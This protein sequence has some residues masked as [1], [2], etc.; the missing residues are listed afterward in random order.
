[1]AAVTLLL[2]AGAPEALAQTSEPT[3]FKNVK[4]WVNPEYDDPLSLNV[5][6]L[7]IMIEGEIVGPP[8][9]VTI[10]FL[11]PTTASMYSAGSKNSFGEYKG[12]P[13]NRK[14]STVPGYDE[15]SYQ[16]TENTFRVE[17]YNPI[18][19]LGVVQR[20]FSYD[21][22]RFYTVQDLTVSVQQP[23][24]SD[25]FSASSSDGQT[26]SSAVDSQGF[27]IQTYKYTNLDASTPIGFS[28]SYNRSVWE[29]SLATSPTTSPASS[30]SSSS[31]GLIVAIVAIAVVL[32]AGGVYLIN[33][34]SQKSRPVSRAERRRRGTATGSKA[35]ASQDTP[36]FCSQCGRKLDRPSRFCPDCGAEI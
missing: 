19:E 13:P 18:A 26:G 30:K 25:N 2:I 5:P 24:S 21:F 16:L 28:I 33:R 6:A 29:P 34:N 15:I 20:S 8:P 3:A 4:I 14:A 1:V 27:P 22:L 10:R 7:L 32:G 11:V 17:Y 31:T 36:A 9:P 35:R 12:G 23:K